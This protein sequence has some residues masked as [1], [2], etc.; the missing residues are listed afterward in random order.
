MHRKIIEEAS[1]NQLKDFAYEVFDMLKRTVDSDV[2]YDVEMELYK[3]VYGC[4]F[5]R[6]LLDKALCCMENE[7]GTKGAHWMVE[8]TTNVA[9]NSGI[10]FEHF[11]EYDWNYVMNMLYSDYHSIGGADTSFY[12]KLA[13]AFLMDKDAPEG[14]ALKYYLAMNE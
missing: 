13:K 7:D 8:Q 2:Y 14:K 3:D 5:T 1:H 4:H 9:Q 10:K 11:N 12:V 6:W